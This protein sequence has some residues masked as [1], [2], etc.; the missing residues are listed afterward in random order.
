MPAQAVAL[1]KYRCGTSPVSKMADNEHTMAA[2]GHSEVLSVES[3]YGPP[4][5]EFFQSGH[6]TGEGM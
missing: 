6:K 1:K 5:A 3:P 2:L 4:V